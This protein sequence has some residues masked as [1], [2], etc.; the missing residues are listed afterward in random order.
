M[1]DTP[2]IFDGHNDV[3]SKLMKAGPASAATR[4]RR[5]PAAAIDLERATAGGFAGGFFAV[6][7]PSAQHEG[8]NYAA[9]AEARFDVALPPEVEHRT[10]LPI[11]L[12]QVAI[13]TELEREGALVICRSVADIESAMA[14]GRL[15]AILH[16]EGVEAIDDDLYALDVFHAAGLR[17]LGPVWSRPNRFG[18]GVPFRFPSSPDVGPGLTDLGMR[19]VKRCNRLK[20]MVDVS[21]L[22]EAGFWD[23][24]R[25]ST[26]PLVATHSN[27][28]ALCRSARNL[29]DRQLAAIKDS[30]GLVGINFATAFLREDGRM[31][32]QVPLG[33]ILEHCDHLLTH[34]GEDGVGFGSDYDG[35]IV[36]DAITSVD[37][38]PRLRQA[39]TDHG[40]DQALMEKLCYRNWMRVLSSTWA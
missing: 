11:A 6:W 1:A 3:L 25:F 30:G 26:A 2:P 19:L 18:H 16:M 10:A 34:L 7:I 31:V 22:T 36:P 4:F 28:H 37:A 8:P 15:A 39:M 23:V 9:M 33:R 5:N 35:A 38:L 14:A 27:A 29:T 20:I 40:Y 13:L 21:H 12:S 32:P 24:A 17:S